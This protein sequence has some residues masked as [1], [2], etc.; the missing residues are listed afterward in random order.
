[1]IAAENKQLRSQLAACS[2]AT[3]LNSK[4]VLDAAIA[5]AQKPLVDGIE[6]MFQA[7]TCRCDQCSSDD[8]GCEEGQRLE[9]IK[10]NA[11]AKVKEGK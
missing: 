2:A 10:L 1:M 3:G 8:D 5:E 4:S 6:L 11:L 9:E 7:H